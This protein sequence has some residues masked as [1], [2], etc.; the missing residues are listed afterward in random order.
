VIALRASKDR[1]EIMFKARPNLRIGGID[2]PLFAVFGLTGTAL[3]WLVVVVQ[4]PGAR[5]TGLS[6]LAVGLIGYWAYRRFVVHAP[7]RAT[8]RAPVLIGPALALEYRSILVPVKPGR[9]SQEAVDVACRLAAER[10]ASI[11]AVAVVVVPLELPL[12]SRLPEVEDE[13]YEVLEQARAIGELYGVDV[14]TRLVRARSAGRA[15]VDEADRRLTEIIV[16][17]APRTSGRRGVFSDTVDFVLKHAPCRV[18]V[19]AGR[20]AA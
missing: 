19:A 7:L 3:A 5:W 9:M 1:D 6:W 10:G 11:A 14:R 8:I 13:A 12:D 17:G 15:I 2:W 4:K 20:K 16:M 18:M